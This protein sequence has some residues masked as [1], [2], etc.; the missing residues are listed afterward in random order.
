VFG[1]SPNKYDISQANNG[2]EP[3]KN[4]RIFVG[5]RAQPIFNCPVSCAAAH[6]GAVGRH[7][8][9]ISQDY[10]PPWIN[11]IWRCPYHKRSDVIAEIAFDFSTEPRIY[12]R[13]VL[14]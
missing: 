7:P 4:A 5:R 12:M 6:P 13:H 11:R 2:M 3:W 8:W 14:D 1:S 9:L 10:C